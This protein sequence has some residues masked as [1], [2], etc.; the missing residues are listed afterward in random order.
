M[1]HVAA[2]LWIKD[3]SALLLL[4]AEHLHPICVLSSVEIGLQIKW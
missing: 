1:K 2:F 3:Q 4:D